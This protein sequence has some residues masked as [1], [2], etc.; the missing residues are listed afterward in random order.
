MAK[1]ILVICSSPEGSDYKREENQE[2]LKSFFPKGYDPDFLSGNTPSETFPT[3][4]SKEKKYYAILFMGCNMLSNLFSEDEEKNKALVRQ[5][6]SLLTPK[7]FII[8]T[9]SKGYFKKSYPEHYDAHALS[10][11]IE[12]LFNHPIKGWQNI[13]AKYAPVVAYWNK[14]FKLKTSVVNGKTKY[15]YYVYMSKNKG[16]AEEKPAPVKEAIMAEQKKKCEAILEQIEKILSAKE[17]RV[18][19]A[20][21]KDISFA[22]SGRGEIRRTTT[23]K[24]TNTNTNTR[25]INA[26]NGEETCKEKLR[27]IKSELENT[28]NG[29]EIRLTKIINIVQGKTANTTATMGAHMTAKAPKKSKPPASNG[30]DFF[31]T[32]DA[33]QEANMSI[34]ALNQI[35]KVNLLNKDAEYDKGAVEANKIL[36]TG[37]EKTTFSTEQG[38]HI[39]EDIIRKTVVKGTAEETV[40]AKIAEEREKSLRDFRLLYQDFADTCQDVNITLECMHASGN[41][42]DCFFHSFFGATSEFY[43]MAKTQ[44]KPYN[45]FVTGFR[46]KI[47]PKIIR[48]FFE[49]EEKPDVSMSEEDLIKNLN[50]PGSFL[51]DDLYTIIAYYY[52]C[53]ILL[54]RPEGADG[55]RVASLIGNNTD[56]TYGISNSAG[57][58]FEPL[59]IFG[60]NT[61]KL[62]DSQAKCL[63]YT[64]SQLSGTTATVDTTRF[65]DMDNVVPINKEKEDG[66]IEYD[67]KAM[68]DIIEQKESQPGD[69]TR[70]YMGMKGEGYDEAKTQQVRNLQELI[71]RLTKN[72]RSR[73][74]YQDLKKSGE[75]Q[76]LEEK[77][78]IVQQGIVDGTMNDDT[79]SEKTGEVEEFL[80][81]FVRANAAKAAK[82]KEEEAKRE[83]RRK[84]KE[85]EKKKGKKGGRRTVRK[86]R[87]GRKTYRA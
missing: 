70:V 13:K 41:N 67:E 17:E 21:L 39:K 61:Y 75:S 24:K 60:D 48:F 6:E 36:K 15:K 87:V 5:I 8:F 81:E 11:T 42:S 45:K 83:E 26:L 30:E 46:E 71:L 85:E 56:N 74:L 80:E 68:K 49:Q 86:Q 53:A 76:E 52:N 1:N 78:Q 69:I 7:G 3:G 73:H 84:K 31:E 66:T 18:A 79:I 32:F 37:A 10:A 43:R 14:I 25:N 82:K 63:S 65:K 23:A 2:M 40:A 27:S 34:E 62:N 47:A 51:S 9:E 44:A 58:H 50:A 29:V 77:I 72:Y 28:R 38:R 64:Y 55:I 33:N 20:V 57:V 35:F 54:I 19:T 59:R 16:E 22:L 12:Q 4:L